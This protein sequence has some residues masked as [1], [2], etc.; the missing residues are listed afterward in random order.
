LLQ[1]LDLLGHVVFLL[2]RV[3]VAR[4]LGMHGGLL[5]VFLQWWTVGLPGRDG[6][7]HSACPE[8][9]RV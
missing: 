5:V 8:V 3:L 6:E 9:P 7:R 2:Y 1:I 4:I